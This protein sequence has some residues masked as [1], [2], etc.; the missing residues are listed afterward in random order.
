MFDYRFLINKTVTYTDRN[1]YTVTSQYSDALFYPTLPTDEQVTIDTN[2]RVNDWV[3]MMQA[4]LPPDP[5][6]MYQI[7]NDDGSI[8]QI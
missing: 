3:A 8:I 4:P 5:D 1:G 7:T 2:N 6:P